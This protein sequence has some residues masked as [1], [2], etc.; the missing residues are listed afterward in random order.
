MALA[1]D[2]YCIVAT[3][4]DKWLVSLALSYGLVPRCGIRCGECGMPRLAVLARVSRLECRHRL[5]TLDFEK[6]NQAYSNQEHGYTSTTAS[7]AHV[8]F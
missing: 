1:E 5:G 2:K 3:Q 6:A 4:A 8:A 7:L